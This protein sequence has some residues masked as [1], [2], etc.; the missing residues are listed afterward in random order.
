MPGGGDRAGRIEQHGI[1]LAAQ[2]TREDVASRAR[3]LRRRATQELVGAAALDPEI[4][5]V[6]RPLPDAPVDDLAH[7]VGPCR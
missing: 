3:V 1:A 4:V 2:L 6:D 7:G 5:R